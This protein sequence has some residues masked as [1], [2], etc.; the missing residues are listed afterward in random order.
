M[1]ATGT[2]GTDDW[3]VYTGVVACLPTTLP[4][5]TQRMDGKYERER[6]VNRFH[7]LVRE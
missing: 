7:D 2:A 1:A 5:Q 3:K 4:G 6:V